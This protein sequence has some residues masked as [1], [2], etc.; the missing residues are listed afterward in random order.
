MRTWKYLQNV[1]R[2]SKFFFLWASHT[3]ELIGYIYFTK[4][5]HDSARK[6][7]KWTDRTAAKSGH[8]RH[9]NLGNDLLN[10]EFGEVHYKEIKTVFSAYNIEQQE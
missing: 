2:R 7:M 3:E 9:S 6:L 1:V 5:I 10:N 4:L 8:F